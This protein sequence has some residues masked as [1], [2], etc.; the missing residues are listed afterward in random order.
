MLK[1]CPKDRIQVEENFFCV[2][3]IFCVKQAQKDTIIY[4]CDFENWFPGLKSGRDLSNDLKY[5][6][7]VS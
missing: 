2:N 7:G 1:S 5:G 3:C 6:N 4:K